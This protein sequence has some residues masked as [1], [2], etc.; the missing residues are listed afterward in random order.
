MVDMSPK[1]MTLRLKQVSQLRR[2]CLELGKM[3]P[4]EHTDKPK[5]SSGAASDQ[6]PDDPKQ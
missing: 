6:Q 3:R 4:V 1:S 2:L 5:T